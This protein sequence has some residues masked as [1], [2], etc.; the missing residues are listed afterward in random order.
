MSESP[1]A[2]LIR[3][4][5]EAQDPAKKRDWAVGSRLLM[6]PMLERLERMKDD[7]RKERRQLQQ[8]VDSDLISEDEMKAQ[9]SLSQEL[10][11]AYQ[12]SLKALLQ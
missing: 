9:L 1:V 7:M 10:I 8:D 3:A 6:E 4:T 2:A 12:Q 5:I 11:N